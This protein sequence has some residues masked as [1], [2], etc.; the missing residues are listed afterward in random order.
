MGP[1][2]YRRPC[3]RNTAGGRQAPPQSR[4]SRRR[5]PSPRAWARPSER[6]D[7]GRRTRGSVP[8]VTL[9][10]R[11][12]LQSRSGCSIDAAPSAAVTSLVSEQGTGAQ[13]P[14]ALL[15]QGRGERPSSGRLCAAHRGPAI[16]PGARRCGQI[17]ELLPR[18]QKDLECT[19][20]SRSA[21]RC[22]FRL[23]LLDNNRSSLPKRPYKALRL[24]SPGSTAGGTCARSLP[25]R[26]R[27]C[28]VCLHGAVLDSFLGVPTPKNP[29][30]KKILCQNQT[31]KSQ[32]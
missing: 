8:P 26:D 9:R 14:R 31:N 27:V 7:S 23:D 3:A 15:L 12:S 18:I 20:P 13:R 6:G 32:K 22:R 11:V 21:R 10:R 4:A 5:C 25:T 24:P 29:I 2:G 30:I 28:R 17:C 1:P 16:T 19:C